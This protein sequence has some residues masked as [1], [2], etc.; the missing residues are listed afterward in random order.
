MRIELFD[1]SK[2]FDPESVITNPEPIDPKTNKFTEDGIFS[3][4]IFGKINGTN[5]SCTCGELTGRF[6]SGEVCEKCNSEV[7][8]KIS[9]ISK[10][11]WIDLEE[12]YIIAP[13]FYKLIKVII[14]NIDDVINFDPDLTSDGI[15]IENS[16]KNEFKNTG[17]IEFRSKFREIIDY[18]YDKNKSKKPV[19]EAYE[20]IYENLRIIFIN[21]IPVYSSILRPANIINKRFTFAIENNDFNS[22]VNSVNVLKSK[23]RL[24]RSVF[25]ELNLIFNIQLFYNNIYNNVNDTLKSKNGLLRSKILGNR[26]NF[27]TRAVISPIP[28]DEDEVDTIYLPYL[29]AVELYKFEIINILA[30]ISNYEEASVKWNNATTKFD[31]GIYTIIIELMKKTKG[32]LNILINRNPSL[33]IGSLLKCRVSKV[34]QDYH[35]KTANISNHILSLISGDY[36]G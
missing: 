12:S 14:P 33:E 16:K 8:Y 27:S 17:L 7:V 31:Q 28:V 19:R 13:F 32:G 25:N 1:V 15:I 2:D 29:A 5:F 6:F 4:R 9:D 34:K 20:C 23:R 22:I 18:F 35:D 3:E 26:I 30:K 21:K 24:E 36:D 10:Q 11:G